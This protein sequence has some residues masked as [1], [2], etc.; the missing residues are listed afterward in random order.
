MAKLEEILQVEVDAEI[1]A[2]LAEADIK[3]AKIVSE[4]E[5][6]AAAR[7]AAHQKKIDAEERAAIQQAQSAADLSLSN[8]RIQAKGEVMDLLRQKVGLALEET[9]SQPGYREVLLA[10]AEE[11]AGVA[12]AAQA[13]VVHPDDQ[14]KLREWAQKR[15]L[16]LRTDPGLRLGVRIV[17]LSGTRVENTLPERL[18]RAWNRLVPK[19]AKLLWE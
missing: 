8:A 14:E 2:I 12:E 3:A 11:A 9:S 1:N 7:V 5:S 15:G 18:H 19:A 13:V 4:A 16:E 10:L 6:L 17:S